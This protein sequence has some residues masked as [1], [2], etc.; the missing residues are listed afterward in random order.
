M[1]VEVRNQYLRELREEDGPVR[2]A[3]KSRLLDEA[4]KRTGVARKVILRKPAHPVTL[5]RGPRAR[6]RRI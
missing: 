1:D 3:H 6:R 5:V 4:V 2:K